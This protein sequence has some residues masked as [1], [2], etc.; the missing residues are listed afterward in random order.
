MFFL[1]IFKIYLTSVFSPFGENLSERMPR[2]KGNSDPRQAAWAFPMGIPG[3]RLDFFWKAGFFS[4]A[5]GL[6]IQSQITPG[7]TSL[8]MEPS[9]QV[10]FYK[11][12][13]IPFN[14]D[15]PYPNHTCVC[16]HTVYTQPII[17][18]NHRH[19]FGLDVNLLLVDAEGFCSQAHSLRRDDFYDLKLESEQMLGCTEDSILSV[20]SPSSPHIA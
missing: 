4:H 12:N 15:T 14:V 10:S 16:T 2:A 13:L 5:L 3:L 6:I 18:P 17:M 19:I 20:G 11:K 9:D 1:K 7:R 8:S